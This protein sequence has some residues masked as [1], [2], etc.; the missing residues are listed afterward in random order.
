VSPSCVDVATVELL[1]FRAPRHCAS[2]KDLI[3]ELMRKDELFPTIADE[4]IRMTIR[5]NI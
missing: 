2:D 3:T 1:E 4:E 5:N